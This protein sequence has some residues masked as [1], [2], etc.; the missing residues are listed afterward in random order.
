MN[1]K[2]KHVYCTCCI[3][4]N[5]L[6]KWE[7]VVQACID[8]GETTVPNPP[9]ICDSCYIDCPWDSRGNDLR[10]NYKESL[11]GWWWLTRWEIE[12]FFKWRMWRLWFI[13][14]KRKEEI[15]KKFYKGLIK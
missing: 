4:W 15:V 11:S 9:K 1:K 2:Y 6:S 13:S 5:N 10:V 8:I 7:D 3:Y 14:N 12:R